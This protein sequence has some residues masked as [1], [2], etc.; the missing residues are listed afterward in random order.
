M[1]AF[2]LSVLET[3]ADRSLFAEVYEQYHNRMEQVAIRI[4]KNQHDAEDALQNAFLQIIRNFNKISDIPCKNRGYWCISVVKN[5]A[6]IILRKKQKTVL[7]DELEG[8]PAA[9][10]EEAVN[11][12]EVVRLFSKLPE[13]YRSILEMRLLLGYSGKEIAKRMDLTENTVNVRISRGRAMLRKFAE[14]EGILP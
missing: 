3:D 6:L 7:K 14:K 4:L 5:E 2:L 10:A 8:G 12:K 1:L 13:T 9:D 11:Y